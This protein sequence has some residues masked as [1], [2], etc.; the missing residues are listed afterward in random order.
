MY[1]MQ[2][3]VGQMER[4]ITEGLVEQ[5][6]RGGYRADQRV[7]DREAPRLSASLPDRGHDVFHITTG[8]GYEVGPTP[9][10]RGLAERALRTLN[11]YTHEDAP[12]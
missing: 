4:T 9:A 12:R 3:L 1:R 11:C 7:L 2:N 8:Q 5:V 6:I 10:G